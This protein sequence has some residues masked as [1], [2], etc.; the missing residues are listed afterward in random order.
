MLLSDMARQV[1]TTLD[2]L[3]A[4]FEA[5]HAPEGILQADAYPG[6]TQRSKAAR[7]RSGMSYARASAILEHRRMWLG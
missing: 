4:G 5:I 7:A 2:T 3:L 1:G 6:I